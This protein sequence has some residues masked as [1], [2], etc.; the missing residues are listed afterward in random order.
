MIKMTAR[1][2]RTTGTLLLACVL[3]VPAGAAQ[4]QTLD[5]IIEASLEAAGGRD[6]VAAITSVRQT[7]TFVMSTGYG[8]ISGDTEVVI[9][10]NQKIYQELDSDLFQQT[11]AWNG[12][13][14][15]QSDNM[16]GT[17]DLE[18]QQA[19]SLE[20]QTMLHPFLPYNT[21]ALGPAEFSKLDDAEVGGRPHHVVEVSRGSILYKFFVD[22][23]TRLVSRIM[24]D[25]DIPQAGR[26]T[27]TGEAS[28]YEEYNGVMLPMR[29]TVDV[30]GFVTIETRYTTV[31]LNGEVDHSI[32]EKP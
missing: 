7:G 27:I 11:G 16:Q 26:V 2:L 30:P 15:W 21:P 9:V 1:M 29:N 12:T 13:A 5:E 3:F 23:E 10:P 22:A 20:F 31:E 18:G 28:G 17:V 14:G 8:D 6:A 25:T 4:A 19:E 24:F 32:F